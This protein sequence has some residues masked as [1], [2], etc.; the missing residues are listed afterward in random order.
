MQA[1]LRRCDVGVTRFDVSDFL[2]TLLLNL[3]S[4]L[5]ERPYVI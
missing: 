5:I 3:E 2:D 4:I 1:K